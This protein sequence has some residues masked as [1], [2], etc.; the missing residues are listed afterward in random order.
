MTIHNAIEQL[1]EDRVRTL[2][3]ET[4]PQS[5]GTVQDHYVTCVKCCQREQTAAANWAAFMAAS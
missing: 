4:V 5:Y 3:G 1:R 2:C